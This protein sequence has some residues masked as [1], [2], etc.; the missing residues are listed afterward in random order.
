MSRHKQVQLMLS[1]WNKFQSKMSRSI[2]YNENEKSTDIYKTNLRKIDNNASPSLAS[3]Q[4]N[5]Q[6]LIPVKSQTNMQGKTPYGDSKNLNRYNSSTGHT[7]QK[8]M[9]NQPPNRKLAH[10]VPN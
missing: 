9:K 8:I 3:L 7:S 10:R 5:H 1:D 4:P 6:T 2:D